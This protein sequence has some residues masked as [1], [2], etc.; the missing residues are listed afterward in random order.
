MSVKSYWYTQYFKQVFANSPAYG[1]WKA[2]GGDT[3]RIALCPPAYVPNQDIHT[4]Y[5][6]IIEVSGQGYTQGGQVLTGKTISAASGAL[7]LG[8]N[9]VSWAGCVFTVRRAVVYD[10]SNTGSLYKQ[11][12]R[13]IDFE[14]DIQLAGDTILLTF[15]GAGEIIITPPADSTPPS[16]S[17]ASIDGPT[18]VLDYDETLDTASVPATSAYTVLVNSV[19]RTV[20]SVAVASDKVVLTLATAVVAK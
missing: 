5:N 12:V 1:G 3:F 15:D 18:L 4:S 17:G 6:D 14:Q 11:L 7:V 19:P 20:N 9:P 10:D 2:S 8:A 16:L 13:W